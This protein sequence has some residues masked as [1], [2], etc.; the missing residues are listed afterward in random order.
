MPVADDNVGPLVAV[1]R[2][3]QW[4]SD[5]ALNRRPE[6]QAS[7]HGCQ[8]KLQA[9]CAQPLQPLQPPQHRDREVALR[10]GRG[11]APG[12]QGCLVP[13]RCVRPSSQP[14]IIQERRLSALSGPGL[15][16]CRTGNYSICTNLARPLSLAQPRSMPAPAAQRGQLHLLICVSTELSPQS[17]TATYWIESNGHG[18]SAG[19]FLPRL[20]RRSF[21]VPV[22]H[23][24]V[25]GQCLP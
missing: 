8:P 14:L 4:L 16:A 24:F 25:D 5:Q 22:S 10:G 17:M 7:I 18:L 1:E 2:V 20:A 9:A 21:L 19:P 12:S 13:S 6:S 15:S 23:R 3:A 11:C